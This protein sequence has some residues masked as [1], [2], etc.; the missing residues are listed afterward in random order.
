MIVVVA[1]SYS[2]TAVAGGPSSPG[3]PPYDA[4]VLAGGAGRR[5]GG[6]DKAALR[7]GG[8]PLLERVLAAVSDAD[9]VLVVGPRRSVSTGREPFWVR[10]RPPG[11]GPL[12]G[13]AAGVHALSSSPSTEAPRGEAESDETGLVGMVG[14]V[15]RVVVVCATDLPWLDD[16]TVR[17]LVTTLGE[18]PATDA[19]MLCDTEG[20]WQPLTAAY[21]SDALATA[22]GAIGDPA[23]RPVRLLFDH[24]DVTTVPGGRHARDIDTPDDLEVA[25]LDEWA[26]RL[27]E[28]L[29]VGEELADLELDPILNLARDAA[30]TIERPAAPVTTF[31]AGY[32]AA[33]RA[34][35]NSEVR[36]CI[37]QAVRFTET[38]GAETSDQS[39]RQSGRQSGGTEQ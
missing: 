38:A 36:A 33:R 27:A 35:G 4:I 39:G 5:L 9:R 32:A 30:H 12:A 10:E 29:G 23:G 8:Q 20:R 31:L 34:S 22:L 14:P 7:V 25:M 19:A 16:R 17:R 1:A 24:L 3:D 21:R 11:S 13:L 28:E 6:V 37:E 26:R 2:T 15:G 18:N